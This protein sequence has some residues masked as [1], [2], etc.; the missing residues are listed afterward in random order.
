MFHKI[1]L[2]S[3]LFCKSTRCV[4]NKE[5]GILSTRTGPAGHSGRRS[6]RI[7][8]NQTAKQS[9]NQQTNNWQLLSHRSMSPSIQFLVSVRMFGL[10]FEGVAGVAHIVVRTKV[11]LDSGQSPKENRTFR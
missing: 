1:N 11:N 9:I 3:I 6:R 2:P 5:S 7:H 4:V 8:S 10:F